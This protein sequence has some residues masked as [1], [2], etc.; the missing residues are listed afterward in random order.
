MIASRGLTISGSGTVSTWT[1]CRPCQVTAR[2][3]V[4]L[5]GLV[6]S[7]IRT[8]RPEGLAELVTSPV[9]RN[10]LSRRRSRRACT[11]G[12]RWKI[13]AIHSPIAAGRADRRRRSREP[14]CRGR[15]PRRGTRPGPELCDVGALDR[16]PG[17]Q[18][19]GLVVGDHR[20]PFDRL[21]RRRLHHPVRAPLVDRVDPLDILHHRGEVREVA[22][23]G[24]DLL[25]R[26]VD[27]DGAADDRILAVAAG[28]LGL[29]VG[30]ARGG[31]RRV[32]AKLV[33]RTPCRT[34]RY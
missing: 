34:P 31:R 5:T 6:R 18:P 16:L 20:V 9:S 33:F 23:E 11:F 32:V 13:L 17:D 8:S 22:P 10:C 21:A 24:V 29:A 26:P 3:F 4:L 7:G 12:S 27:R 14:S 19:A 28:G 1:L 15:A 30:V 2:I 25:A